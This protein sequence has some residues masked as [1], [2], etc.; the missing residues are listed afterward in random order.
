MSKKKILV[1]DDEPELV[2]MVKMRL[3][4][5]NYRVSTASDGEE[6]LEKAKKEKPDLILLD[7]SMPNKDGY[8]FLR[9]A[10][11]NESIK[12]IPVIIL[13]AFSKMEDLFEI[14]GV[15]DYIMKPFDG[16]QLLEKINKYLE[17]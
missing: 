8:T 1:V 9:E 16:Q 3:E 15:K 6:A 4:A 10:K 5:G 11:K 13:T 17:E 12:D 7:I 2:D 14:E